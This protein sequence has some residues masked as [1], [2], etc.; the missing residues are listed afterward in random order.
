MNGV[1][2]IECQ[3]CC[4]V[5][6]LTQ[7]SPRHKNIHCSAIT[8]SVDYY[9]SR[10]VTVAINAWDTSPSNEDADRVDSHGGD[11]C[12]WFIRG[13]MGVGERAVNRNLQF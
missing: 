11:L 12:W 3:Q 10:N 2:V 7:V 6:S 13:C 5:G 4:S 8:H 1:A 9:V